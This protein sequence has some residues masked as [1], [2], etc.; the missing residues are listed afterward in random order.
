MT[1]PFTFTERQL[2]WWVG[3]LGVAWACELVA[4]RVLWRPSGSIVGWQFGLLLIVP[5]AFS[6]FFILL[7]HKRWWRKSGGLLA[8]IRKVMFWVFVSAWVVIWGGII[9][10]LVLQWR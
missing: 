10:R 8:P 4:F 5:I 6:L 9:K 7:L 3:G 2:G 1:S